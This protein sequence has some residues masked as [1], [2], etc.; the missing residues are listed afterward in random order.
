MTNK[1]REK[2]AQQEQKLWQTL[3]SRVTDLT[4]TP[5]CFPIITF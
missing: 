2:F 1:P 3:A 4:L 5:S